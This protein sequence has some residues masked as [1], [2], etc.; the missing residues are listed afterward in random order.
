MVL[1]V[2]KANA[3]SAVDAG[4]AQVEAANTAAEAGKEQ[5]KAAK[6]LILNLFRKVFS[7]PF[8]HQKPLMLLQ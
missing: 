8:Q 4:K 7:P 2:T 5:A 1:R 3:K 6:L